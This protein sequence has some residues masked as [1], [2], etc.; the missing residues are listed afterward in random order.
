MSSE[1]F[2]ETISHDT[3]KESR[4]E[5]TLT[6]PKRSAS[7]PNL[8]GQS[9]Q[10]EQNLLT[11][12]SSQESDN[13]NQ[14]Y[15]SDK[16]IDHNNNVY[17]NDNNNMNGSS[18]YE[19]TSQTYTPNSSSF[20]PIPSQYYTPPFIP[21]NGQYFYDHNYNR[22]AR[23]PPQMTPNS[24]PAFIKSNF[25]PYHQIPVFSSLHPPP[26]QYHN[27]SPIFTP[28]HIQPRYLNQSSASSVDSGF[29][30]RR[31]SM[32]QLRTPDFDPQNISRMYQQKKPKQ[33]DKA[34]W[35]GNLPETTTYEELEEFFEDENMESVFLIKKSNCA[36][37]NYKSHE[38]VIE[39]V[40]K[41]NEKDFKLKTEN[42]SALD[43]EH[44][45]PPTPS[46]AGSTTSS[47]SHRS[48]LP[49][50]RIKQPS[51]SSMSP[52]SSVSSLKP[53]SP[54]RYFILKSLTQDDLDIS[55]QNGLWAT[56]PHNEAALNKAF[57]SAENVYL[58]FSANKSGEFY[59]YARMLSPISK[60]STETVQWTPI[61]EAA[62]AAS[63]SRPSPESVPS[64]NWGTTFKVEWIKVQKLPFTRTRHLRNPWNANREVK[65][66]RDGT[67]VEP[68][69]GE[70]LLAEFHKPPHQNISAQYV[71]ISGPLLTQPINLE[72]GNGQDRSLPTQNS[73]QTLQN[74][75]SP[76][77]DH[78]YIQTPQ[79][80]FFA[81]PPGYWHPQHTILLPPYG[82]PPA[83]AYVSS[84]QVWANGSSKDSSGNVTRPTTVV[85]AHHLYPSTN[86]NA[87]A[88]G[89]YQQ[90][91]Y[92]RP[93][94]ENNH[95]NDHL[96][97]Q[98]DEE[99]EQD[100]DTIVSPQPNKSNTFPLSK[101]SEN[102][103]SLPSNNKKTNNNNGNNTKN[104]NYISNSFKS[105]FG[106]NNDNSVET[107]TEI[108]N[109]T[110]NHQD[111]NNKPTTSYTGSVLKKFTWC[112]TNEITSTTLVNE[113]SSSSMSN[114]PESINENNDNIN[115]MVNLSSNEINNNENSMPSDVDK[116]NS[117]TGLLRKFNSYRR[118]SEHKDSSG[119]T[120]IEQDEST[121]TTDGKIK[122]PTL[123]PTRSSNRR[124]NF[125][126]LIERLKKLKQKVPEK[127]KQKIPEKLKQKI[128]EKSKQKIPDNQGPED[129]SISTQQLTAAESSKNVSSNL[130]NG[131]DPYLVKGSS[132][133]NL[134]KGVEEHEKNDDDN[135]DRDS[136][137]DMSL[138]D[139]E[140]GDVST[141]HSHAPDSSLYT[142]SDYD[143]SSSVRQRLS[144]VS[145]FAKSFNSED[146]AA[147]VFSIFSESRFSNIGES[148]P[149][150]SNHN[151]K[152]D[153]SNINNQYTQIVMDSAWDY[154]V[155]Q[156]Q[157][158]N[159]QKNQ[160]LP[161]ILDN[162]NI[163]KP[164]ASL[165]NKR[166]SYIPNNFFDG[167][168]NLKE[169]SLDRNNL[170]D[171]PDELL[172]LTKLEKLDLSYISPITKIKTLKELRLNNNLLIDI[173][174]DITKLIKL[175]L[176]YLE[177]N[178]LV[179]LP[180][181]LNKL[182]S[183]CILKLS[184]N[185]IEFLP[186]SICLLKQLQ[187]LELKS[188][189][190]RKLP[191]NIKELDNL[192]LLDISNNKIKSL[193][194]DIVKLNKLRHLNCSNNLIESLPVRIGQLTKLIDLNLKENKL[195][196]LP[197]DLSKLT[198]LTDL[199]LS[200]NE[201]V[202]L[203]EDLGKLSKLSELKLNNN[204]SLLAIPETFRKLSM[205]KKIYLQ[206]CSLKQIP[207]ELGVHY[208]KLEYINLSYNL[209]DKL[210]S[211]KG[212]YRLKIFYITNNRLNILPEEEL[213]QLISLEEFY[214]I[215]NKIKYLSRSIG[216]L[217]KLKVLDLSENMLTKLPLTIGDCENLV[218]L[219]LRGNSLQY[220]PKTIS[221][222][223]KLKIF[224]V[225]DW[226]INDFI[227]IQKEKQKIREIERNTNYNTVNY[228]NNDIT[229]ITDLQNFSS[230]PIS[231]QQD[232]NQ[233]NDTYMKDDAALKMALMMK[234][235]K[236]IR[237]TSISANN[238]FG[239]GNITIG[240]DY[241]KESIGD[242][243]TEFSGDSGKIKK[244]A[245][246]K[247]L[248]HKQ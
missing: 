58:I 102:P 150:N 229:H 168:Y 134:I 226:P 57:K 206:H 54:N 163:N 153:L 92:Y 213:D 139:G 75:L 26:P 99:N 109:S 44:T 70:R 194:N 149:N 184:N 87:T 80:T 55:V 120:V 101:H 6:A 189:L 242:D 137:D 35:V 141:T 103:T 90:Q 46:E 76:M 243:I 241:D 73:N 95:T 50:R 47:R 233:T 159:H 53:S 123:S 126:S 38:A 68:V 172:R 7:H 204:P 145:S 208:Q 3:Y 113:I 162:N 42:L 110:D 14:N 51:I 100:E 111:S 234:I 156:Q 235:L 231:S 180:D 11:P 82:T 209:L 84:Q 4:G 69:V 161:A 230:E 222:L 228:N 176:L 119:E 165:S 43:S 247:F 48:S 63:S 20:I 196:D 45:P 195:S 85:P 179:Y 130:K 175:R 34:L 116:S 135:D 143:A 30:S 174:S 182:K 67:E 154:V 65:I 183:L 112:A 89:Q 167:L 166:L 202:V 124:S 215:N 105:L 155:N 108:V 37:V 185:N 199:D 125:T 32:D 225:G 107:T 81:P 197:T 31:S 131:S 238:N 214:L 49:P 132:Q 61:D 236:E 181:T 29:S 115:S 72:G 148:D 178:Q 138:D 40:N 152:S 177:N 232:L 129:P 36:F 186:E 59:G 83:P 91:Q 15:S 217:K 211:L 216:K 19:D 96:S 237:L 223:K 157:G 133:V 144:R 128:P 86:P 224:Y 98:Q 151:S 146:P 140:E 33:L 64:R 66:S 221:N 121:T 13:A 118:K 191:E 27:H 201:L 207:F 127:L 106:Y 78:N 212:M 200:F 220:L 41:Y 240:N 79:P 62:L 77:M 203:P 97:Y 219:K 169:L 147:S 244:F 52:A 190:L 248:K 71:N 56:Q 158:P 25:Y 93:I 94:S 239:T 170:R 5:S 142:G 210:P 104:S 160:Q 24:H 136:G 192:V 114:L 1:E 122:T 173:S 16:D 88:N 2:L 246:F 60:E 18:N 218:E 245:K 117:I 193:P 227:I 21:N 17:P 22:F 8:Q 9:L 171:F 23:M 187:L 39:A 28:Q 12:E 10:S 164:P 198:S 74:Q 188:N 205:V